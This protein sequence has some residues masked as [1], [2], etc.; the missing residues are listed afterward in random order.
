[1]EYL[2]EKVTEANIEQ[3]VHGLKQIHDFNVCHRDL[4]PGNVRIDSSGTLKYYD[5]GISKVMS[6]G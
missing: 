1:M 6:G 5:F 4:A 2:P 3:L